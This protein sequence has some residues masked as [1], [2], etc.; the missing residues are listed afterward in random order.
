[1]D[2]Q[3]KPNKESQSSG[4]DSG[5]TKQRTYRVVYDPELDQ[6]KHKQN[7]QIIRKFE[8][9]DQTSDP[10]RDPRLSVLGYGKNTSKG[11]KTYR[12]KLI[13]VQ[14]LVDSNSVVTKHPVAI[15]VSNLSPL[16]TETH[17]TTHFSKYGEVM[18]VTI[19]K[20]PT[21]GG[22]LG[23]ARVEFDANVKEAA[24]RA[25][26]HSNGRYMGRAGPLRVELDSS[27][28]KLKAIVT[29]RTMRGNNNHSSTASNSSSSGNS[30]MEDTNVIGRDSGGS[31]N[32]LKQQR[33]DSIKSSSS[34]HEE[35]EVVDDE[36]SPTTMKYSNS[37][38][39]ATGSGS[40]YDMKNIPPPPPP[41]AP[42]APPLSH[43]PYHHRSS[44]SYRYDNYRGYRGVPPPPPPPHV[45][46]GTT[47]PPPPPPPPP[48]A[49][50]YP[51]PPPPPSSRHLDSDHYEPTS[52]SNRP[53][54]PR[55]NSRGSPSGSPSPGYRSRSRSRSRSIG[56]EP[57]GYYAD[58]RWDEHDYERERDRER[59]RDWDRGR[60]RRRNE[61]WGPAQERRLREDR[62]QPSLVI[63]RQCLPFQRGILEDLRKLFYYYNC[64][65]LYHD[66]ENWHIVFDSTSAAKRGFTAANGQ[67]LMGYTLTITLSDPTASSSP[68]SRRDP[69]IKD[70]SDEPRRDSDSASEA[71]PRSTASV[72]SVTRS[73]E[74]V[75]KSST[76]KPDEEKPTTST[77]TN[78]NKPIKEQAKDLLMEELANVFVKDLKSRVVGPA[79]NDFHNP[80]LRKSRETPG[81]P[82]S[83]S[84]G[85]VSRPVT[86]SETVP[87]NTA[88]ITSASDTHVTASVATVPVSQNDREP[89][90]TLLPSTS[91]SSS[92]A[93][94]SLKPTEGYLPSISKLPRIKKRPSSRVHEPDGSKIIKKPRYSSDEES[95]QDE[96]SSRTATPPPRH[97]SSYSEQ[98][99]HTPIRRKRVFMSSSDEEEEL[100]VENGINFNHKREEDDEEDEEEEGRIHLAK[101]RRSHKKQQQKQ[102]RPRTLR[103]YLSDES[104][105]DQE[106][107]LFLQQLQRHNHSDDEDENDD[108]DREEVLKA[109]DKTKDREIERKKSSN[110]R[111]TVEVVDTPD[112]LPDI[113]MD[114]SNTIKKNDRT[115]ATKSSRHQSATA[116]ERDEDQQ[117]QPV[118]EYDFF[119]DPEYITH[120]PIKRRKRAPGRPKKNA[121][122]AEK[123]GTPN[124]AQIEE[125]KR[126]REEEAERQA[127]E[128]EKYEQSLLDSDDSDDELLSRTGLEN[129]V[130][131]DVLHAVEKRA[132]WDPFQQVQDGEDFEFLRMAILEKVRP[133]QVVLRDDHL[134][135]NDPQEGGKRK[136]GCARA[137]GYYPIPDS[138]K[139]TYLPRNRAVFDNPSVNGRTT[140]RTNRVNNRRLLVGMDMQKKSLA[141]SDILKF[142]QLKNRKKQLRFAKSPIHDWGLFAE[143]RIDANDMV[144]EYVGEII[145][146]QVAEER[147]KKYE[148]CGIGSSY[149]FRVDDDTVIDATKKGSIARFI[150]H[151][152]SPNCSA[153]IITVDKQKKIV[154]YA[155]RDIEPGEEITYDYKFPIEADKIPCLCGS[156]FCKGTLN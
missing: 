7:Q 117:P 71:P 14:F 133:D 45:S 122:S 81:P 70:R 51:P 4:K 44:S 136:D 120:K 49:S 54:P 31:S 132:E 22:S 61:Y 6:S 87:N 139:A 134:N 118:E 24:A 89:S 140:S 84:S 111:D 121:G 90:K 91:S 126:A 55:W 107:D 85:H 143:E 75:R 92:S 12:P 88:T 135:E 34:H 95:D 48:Y 38:S 18:L 16:A 46:P 114:N 3:C 19:E 127:R 67:Q 148:R 9:D 60:Y 96:E 116:P 37:N 77:K 99:S 150:N 131:E 15:V 72:S 69:T 28:D 109:S 124:Q 106:H 147:E 32:S 108:E 113:H 86:P 74:E 145:R 47:P 65:D 42:I 100:P 155:N 76:P 79:I 10:P 27:G 80:E 78:E 156:K 5:T 137:R 39:G 50:R 146:Q 153:K 21:T 83:S 130:V 25:V 151:C 23:V 93:A 64:V 1:M 62:D 63:S 129:G 33:T 152:C 94:P 30:R 20:C 82:P 41:P 123:E 125:E 17:I 141:D 101:S 104:E 128:Q 154:I 59:E 43:H 29:E 68:S 119:K 112:S 142:N 144:I 40:R 66:E 105:V 26:E 8:D 103:D 52:R 73:S 53:P 102:Q 13:S 35:G 149:L 138:I 2:S 56:R 11:N 97:R 110:P 58:R 36:L 57:R 98:Q 115:I